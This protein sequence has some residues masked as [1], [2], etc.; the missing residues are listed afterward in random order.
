MPLG[1]GELHVRDLQLRGLRH[2]QPV[3]IRTL[4]LILSVQEK[5]PPTL[6]P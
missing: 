4:S 5:Q 1:R 6:A 2:S 3:E